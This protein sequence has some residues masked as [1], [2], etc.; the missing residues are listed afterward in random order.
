MPE[1]TPT[2]EDP[3]LRE[4]MLRIQNDPKLTASERAAR[5]QMLSRSPVGEMGR[6]DLYKRRD[7]TR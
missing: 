6:R 2:P 3:K 1:G 5:I 4:E 7:N